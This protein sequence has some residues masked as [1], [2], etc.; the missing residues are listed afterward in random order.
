VYQEALEKE[1]IK[2]SIPHVCHPKL[3]I[4]YESEKM[5]KFFVVD[6]VCYSV[7]LLELKASPYIHP[8]NFIQLSIN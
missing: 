1:F 7:I 6:F 2:Q 3:E 8:D 5:K 4:F